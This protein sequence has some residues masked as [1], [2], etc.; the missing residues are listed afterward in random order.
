MMKG[1]DPIDVQPPRSQTA[2][3]RRRDTSAERC[4]S[5]AREAWWRALAT[6]ATLEEDIEQLS[7]PI[8]RGWSGACSRS[9]DHHG[10]RS[11]GQKRRCCHMQLEES[12][13]PYF[14][15]QPPWRDPES[16]EDEEVPVDFKLGAPLEP[17]MGVDWFLQ[18]LAESSEEEDRKVPSPE[19]PVEELESWVI[20]RSWMQDMPGW[21]QELPGV[22]GVDDPKKLA[23]EVWASFQLPWRISKQ[24]RVENYHQAP[25][26]PSCLHCKSFLPLSNSQFACWDIR[27][28]QWEKTVAYAKALQ[29]WAEKANL[30]TWGKWC[31]LVGSVGELREEMKSYVSFTDEDIFS[32]VALPEEPHETQPKEATL[33]ST[34]PTQADPPLRRPLQR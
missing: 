14:E 17:G 1:P 26:A 11:R 5:K 31:L 30:P 22:P 9:R 13:A 16:M 28:L 7:Q 29:F 34:N 27:E 6:V 33:K 8:T 12:L 20:W 21:W 19:P 2:R 4:L 18:G 10:Q 32:D 3:R 23:W 15:Y 24:H 25:P